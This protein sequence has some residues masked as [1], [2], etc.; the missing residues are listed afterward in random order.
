ME[1]QILILEQIQHLHSPFTNRLFELITMT[2]EETFFIILAA[3]FLWCGNKELGYRVG[4][5]F[6][7]STVINPVLK[8]TFRIE[9]PIGLSEIESMRVHTATGF[10]FPSGHTQGATSFWT[11]IMSYVRRPWMYAV[12]IAMIL[13]VG[14]SR[15]Y[16]GVH[17]PTDVLGGILIGVL[18]VLLVNL[19]YDR[20]DEKEQ[21]TLL[22]IIIIPLFAGYLLFP[23]ESYVVSLGALTGFWIGYVVER[24]HIGYSIKAAPA[25]Q[26]LKMAV[27]LA[28]LLLIK[29]GLKFL[30]PF[31]YR[32]SDLIRYA[33]IGFWLTAGAPYLFSKVQRKTGTHEASSV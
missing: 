2:A 23:D 22:L 15:M 20:A 16:L 13:L 28:V 12:G 32:L 14:F 4:F 6:L 19:V 26:L 21:Y 33:V 29:E 18:W 3:W 7:S 9:R 5:A 24:K 30:L 31:D 17:W 27:G 1:L 25:V 10:A 8:N 11:G